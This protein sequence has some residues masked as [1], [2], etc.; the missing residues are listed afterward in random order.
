MRSTC[1]NASSKS[2][3]DQPPD[4]EGLQVVGVVVAGAQR[5]RAE[6]DAAL[7]LGAEPFGPRAAIHAHQRRV[8][9]VER[10]AASP[11][12]SSALPLG[13]QLGEHLRLVGAV[14]VVDA[15]V[16]GQVARRFARGDHVVRGDAV[17]A[18]R[19][20]DLADLGAERL[21]DADRR[22]ARPLRLR[23]SSPAAKCSRT[24]PSLQ[25]GERLVDRSA[26]SAAPAGRATSSRAGRARRSPPAAAPRLRPCGPAGRPGR[27][28]WR[29]RPGRSG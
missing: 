3:A 24:T 8:E 29:T 21:V 26:S 14:A 15:V 13:G 17:L 4:L 20:R 10:R 11:A 2:L 28:C 6:H 7:H 9:V 22:R 23:A 18:V 12:A 25:P 27:G 1:S 19:Q 16:A 5:V